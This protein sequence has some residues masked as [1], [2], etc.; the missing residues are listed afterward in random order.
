MAAHGIEIPCDQRTDE[1]FRIRAGHLTGSRAKDALSVGKNGKPSAMRNRLIAELASTRYNPDIAIPKS[2]FVSGDMQWGIDQEAAALSAYEETV[3]Q[4]RRE[5]VRVATVGFL[6]HPDESLWC[7]CSPDGVV[8]GRLIECKALASHNHLDI[9]KRRAIPSHHLP[10]LR[11][12]LFVSG[13]PV[14]DFVSYDPRLPDNAKIIVLPFTREDA[15]LDD[16]AQHVRDF[17]EEVDSAMQ[18]MENFTRHG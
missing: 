10:Q 4:D 7:G 1:G 13:E 14:C 15:K 8:D 17:M 9:L 11:H 5:L 18:L 12:N 2:A 16:Y 6:Q 3:W